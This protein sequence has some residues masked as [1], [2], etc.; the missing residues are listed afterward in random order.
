MPIQGNQIPS[1]KPVPTPP[2]LPHKKLRVSLIIAIIAVIILIISGLISWKVYFHT[3]NS[4]AKT[5]S[6]KIISQD[7]KPRIL[8]T[9]DEV[10]PSSPVQGDNTKNQAKPSETTNIKDDNSRTLTSK[11]I[12]TYPALESAHQSINSLH[13]IPLYF[14]AKDQKGIIKP[15]WNQNFTASLNRISK[16]YTNQFN[17]QIHIDYKNPGEVINGD[18]PIKDYTFQGFRN[19]VFNKTSNLAQANSFNVWVV[20]V[21]RDKNDNTMKDDLGGISGDGSGKTSSIPLASGYEFWLDNE[22]VNSGK[23]PYG[24]VGIA[25]EIGHSLGIPHPW[26]LKSNINHTPNYGNVP[27]DLMAYVRNNTS[28]ENMYIRD[29]IKKE[30]GL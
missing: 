5:P 12:F 20:I 19:E 29:D 28:F 13:L 25:H 15:N 2:A 3:S 21:I 4:T 11:E 24:V 18:M 14:V 17:N 9:K 7:T 1:S 30:M 22:A 6:T 26:D 27:E 23:A 10:N 8:K 16:F